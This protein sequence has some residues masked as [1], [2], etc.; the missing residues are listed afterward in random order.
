METG[1]ALGAI[2][3]LTGVSLLAWAVWSWRSA[4]FGE[5]NPSVTMRQQA[6]PGER[7]QA[8]RPALRGRLGHDRLDLPCLGCLDFP[9]AAGGKLERPGQ[10]ERDRESK[11]EKGDH[12]GHEG[13]R[14][15]HRVGERIRHLDQTERNGA[16][17]R[18]H[19]AEDRR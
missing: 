8:G 12:E 17:D 9:D 2:V 11:D 18:R 6:D 4:E 13:S 14:Q 19:L 1:I 10:H 16:V 3:F 15:S 7:Q 5:L